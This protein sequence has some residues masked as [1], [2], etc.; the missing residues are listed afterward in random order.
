M[1]TT[2]ST[3]T[4]HLPLALRE[5]AGQQE[6]VRVQGQDVGQALSAL[7]ETYPLVGARLLEHGGMLRRHVNLFLGEHN[8]RDLQGLE[9]PL[10]TG[11]EIFI[12]PAVAGG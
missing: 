8:V 6:T 4:F 5:F 9:T 10:C 3:V 2:S 12:I 1:N 7:I 11:D